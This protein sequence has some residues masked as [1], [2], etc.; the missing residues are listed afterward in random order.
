[1]KAIKDIYLVG[2]HCRT[3]SM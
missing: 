3:C 2:L 1:V